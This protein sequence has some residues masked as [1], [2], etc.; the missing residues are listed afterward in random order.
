MVNIRKFLEGIG[1]IPKTSSTIDT[2]GEMEVLDSDGKLHYHNGTSASPMVTE[3][4]SASLTNK[5]ID[6][7]QNT[8]TNI[9][10][11]DIKAGAAIDAAKIHDGSV[12]NAEFGYLANVTS[13]IQTQLNATASS[14]ALNA[15]INDTTDAHMASAIGNTPSGNLAATNV[16][17]ALNELQS[18]VDTRALDSVVSS[19]ISASTGVHGVTGSVVGTSDSQVLTNKTI[20]GDDN[21]LQD[22]G[23]F[24]LKTTL[25]DA[26]KFLVRDGSGIVISN[27][28][29]VPSGVV[30]GDS[31]SQTLTNKTLSSPVVDVLVMDDQASTPSNPAAG[32]IKTYFKTDG[33]L[34]KL[35]SAGVESEVSASSNATSA[36]ITQT[37]HGLVV[38]NVVRYN[39]AAYVKAQA[40]SNANSEVYGMVSEVIDANTFRL[41]TEGYVSGLSGLSAGTAY[42]LSPTTAGAITSTEPS[43]VGQISKPV[44]ITDSISSGYVIQSRGIEVID[45]SSVSVLTW[46]D[47]TSTPSNPA[48]GFYKTYFKTDGILYKLNS[49]GLE[50]E[51]NS[52]SSATSIKISQAAHGFSVGNIL[53]YNGS[54]YVKSQADSDANAEIYGMVSQIIDVDTFVLVTEGRVSGLSGLTAGAT[55]Y[56]SPSVAGEMTSIEPTTGGQVSKPV[57]ITD[58][59]T[60]GYVIQSRG[61]LVGPPSTPALVMS[62]WASYTPTTQGLGTLAA[63][64]M[65]Y[66]RVGDSIEVLGTLT[67]GTVSPVEMRIGLPSGLIVDSTKV[68]SIRIVGIIDRNATS[69][70]LMNASVEPNAT[71]M[72][73]TVASSSGFETKQNGSFIST[74]QK[75]SISARIPIAGWTAT[76]SGQVSAPRSY[77]TC[78]QSPGNGSVNTTVLR[79]SSYTSIGS[80]ITVTQSATDGDKFTVNTP[81]I[82]AITVSYPWAGAANFGG[83]TINSSALS[84]SINSITYAQGIRAMTSMP[85]GGPFT[86]SWTGFLSSGDIIRAQNDTNKGSVLD[87]RVQLTIVQ[88]S[89]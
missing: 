88:V 16:Q 44:F 64:S 23:L 49:A 20:D 19:H 54:V 26:N 8:I 43:T 17:S 66:R 9:E 56:L 83:I 42:Y 59:I 24:S 57:F 81:G 36:K 52:S 30:V 72:V 15:H 6:A 34:Y 13:D 5:T 10:N 63:S 28:K 50:S 25:A 31:D 79:W 22:I 4:H 11:A 47:Q 55:Y 73:L 7:D 39:G 77:V 1:L 46:D 71:Y 89:N 75:L 68:S 61:L 67:A 48:S 32:Y 82:Y 38:G 35:D 86:V 2:K 78:L 65:F 3:A 21:T 37:S 58:S 60:S 76:S 41:V 14:A 45:N 18:D 29:A 33:K 80:S 27:T 69:S 87:D 12:S 70:T 74:G 85:T 40:N 84:T 62:D 51:V 53:R